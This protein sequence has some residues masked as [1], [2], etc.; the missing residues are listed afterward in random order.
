MK[1]KIGILLPNMSKEFQQVIYEL[2]VE[3]NIEIVYT[4]GGF[5]KAV[6]AAKTLLNQHNDIVALLARINSADILRNYFD[7]PVINLELSD[8]DFAKAI[9]E[10]SA[11]DKSPILLFQ[12]YGS[13][14]FYDVEAL[15]KVC[16]IPIYTK[17]MHMDT[18][19]DYPQIA[20]SMNIHRVI[21]SVSIVA[22]PCVNSGLDVIIVPFSRNILLKAIKE[23]LSTAAQFQKSKNEANKIKESMDAIQDG[24]IS[25]DSKNF[26]AI[27]NKAMSAF[28]GV[29]SEKIVNLKLSEAM[30]KYPFI[31]KVFQAN[32]ND[33]IHHNGSQYAVNVIFLPG[34]VLTNT[35]R[36]VINIPELQKKEL[37]IREKLLANNYVARTS[38]S[39]I[40]A[41]DPAM[42]QVC[43]QAKRYAPTNSN[44]LIT[45]ES[46]TGKEVLAQS[47][48]NE[49]TC[50]QGAFIAINCAAIPETLLESELFGYEE[51]AFTGAKKGGKVGL[52]ELSH[53]GTLFLD[54]IGLIPYSLQ[55]KLLRVIQERQISRL[56]GNNLIHVR[57]RL[58]CATNENLPDLIAQ[59]K[60]REDLFYRINVLPLRIPNLRERKLDII[61]LA[62]HFIKEKSMELGQNF[63]VEDNELLPLLNYNWPGNVR[64]LEAFIERLIV[65]QTEDTIQM[66]NILNLM[67]T[68]PQIQKHQEAPRFITES[69][70]AQTPEYAFSAITLN[71][72][73]TGRT[74]KD[75]EN[76]AILAAYRKHNG[77]LTLIREELG[78]SRTTL[79]KKL[80]EMQLQ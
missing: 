10:N 40:I 21:T 36:A 77:N 50:R 71:Y 19:N 46:G 17:M 13:S 43:D 2:S 54:E 32:N 9:T 69:K 59:G 33:I 4:E 38:F 57:N 41:K 23:A 52:I 15:S 66:N 14:K 8:F 58:I 64:Q 72:A 6:Q 74:L 53:N 51:G 24:I 39:N 27:C 68:L 29:P 79:W 48:H 44:I 75:I 1:P 37:A 65:L 28:I 56:G 45:G 78:I 22:T 34:S 25:T 42:Q 67:H 30:K 76:D 80:K 7:I 11:E 26:I 60:F 47:I 20:R 3:M 70:A 49:S 73:G 18:E 62:K 61:P 12:F 35:S 31:K 5:T 63:I 16:H 55:A